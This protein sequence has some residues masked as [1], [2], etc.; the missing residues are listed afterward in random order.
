MFLRLV[1]ISFW[2]SAMMNEWNK[3]SRWD[4][5]PAFLRYLSEQRTR[6]HPV[7]RFKAPSQLIW[8][9]CNVLGD[10]G[11]QHHQQHLRVPQEGA[12]SDGD[13]SDDRGCFFK[14]EA[15]CFNLIKPPGLGSYNTRHTH[16][17][18]RSKY[19]THIH[20]HEWHIKGFTSQPKHQ[21][22]QDS[23]M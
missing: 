9:V 13:C 3:T 5:Y 10:V 2:C 23:E 16:V 20:G 4:S 11:V 12:P 21:K 14:G 15:S 6:C 7:S 19:K 1:I 8:F 22:V 17:Q 18:T